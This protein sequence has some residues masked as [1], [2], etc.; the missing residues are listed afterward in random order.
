MDGNYFFLEDLDDPETWQAPPTPI[1]LPKG[2]EP[3]PASLFPSEN[4]ESSPASPLTEPPQPTTSSS[5]LELPD[6][7]PPTS[8]H[9]GEAS[10]PTASGSPKSSGK[11][12]GKCLLLTWSQAPQ[13]SKSVICAHLKT[14][15][16]VES[17][18]IG[19]ENHADG[20]IHFHACVLYR[21]KI[22]RRPTAFALLGRSADVRVANAKK[23][24]LKDCIQNFWTYAQK[25]DPNPLL[26]GPGP[27]P[28]KRTRN[29][30]YLE[31]ADLAATTSVDAALDF[32]RLN[33]AADY[34]TKLDSISRSLVSHRNKKT[35]H[36]AP[37][38]QL[39][40]F[41]NAPV[42]P[43]AWRVL[44]LW[45]KSGAGKTQFAKALLPE[46]S[47]IRHRNQLTDCDFSK[48]VIFDD[49]DVSHWP[50]TAVI[51]LL[52]WDEVTGTDVK[53]G[54]VIIPS[55]T[56][57]IFTFNRIPDAWCPPSISEEQFQAV[58]RR[59]TV[60]EINHSLF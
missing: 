58:L 1:S 47:I 22:S 14:L 6:G 24:P 49:F 48:G 31:A 36:L 30:I 12:Q 18:A 35:R 50:P 25:E 56:R 7:T 4:G 33:A 3:L 17:L 39:S 41:A 29:Q 11:V 13:L 53:H 32:V 54:Y 5:H 37:A 38:R 23:G 15:G 44:F 46:A 45:G 57:K 43:E 26:E 42:I 28:Q 19:Q 20:G 16:E 40:E 59:M 55:H 34:V 27:Q 2:W 21:E 60:I 52:D 51:H 8:G 10:V 9:S